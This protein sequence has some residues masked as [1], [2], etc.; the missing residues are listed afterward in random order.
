MAVKVLIRLISSLIFVPITHTLAVGSVIAVAPGRMRN[1]F[2]PRQQAAYVPKSNLREYQNQGLV[3]ERDPLFEVERLEDR[4]VTDEILEEGA[5][6][7]SSV[8][9][10]LLSVKFIYLLS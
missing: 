6:G 8:Q 4:K 1:S 5:A 3:V 7:L 9:I 2:Y 10:E